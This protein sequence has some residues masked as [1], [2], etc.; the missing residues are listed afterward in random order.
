MQVAHLGRLT[1]RLPF[2]PV[3]EARFLSRLWKHREMTRIDL[4]SSRVASLPLHEPDRTA[5]A[6]L[7]LL[8]EF[9]ILARYEW[10]TWSRRKKALG[11]ITTKGRTTNIRNY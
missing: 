2:D 11:A 4:K 1:A 8:H 5:E 3:S 6:M 7:C 9:G 10:R